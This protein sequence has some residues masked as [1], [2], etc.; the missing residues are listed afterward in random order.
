M[1]GGKSSMNA[2][3]YIRGHLPDYDGWRDGTP[4]GVGTACCPCSSARRTSARRPS[5]TAPAA[6]SHRTAAREPPTQAFSG[7]VR[8]RPAG[9]DLNGPDKDGG[10]WYR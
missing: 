7:G 10:G 3:V 8:G 5:N 6:R 2:L 9:D 1:L 4:A